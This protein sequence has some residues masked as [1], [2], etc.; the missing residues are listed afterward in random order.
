[1]F[2]FFLPVYIL[3][4]TVKQLKYCSKY[5][6]SYRPKYIIYL[7]FS[8]AENLSEVRK[9][10]GAIKIGRG[11]KYGEKPYRRVNIIESN[12]TFCVNLTK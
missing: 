3:K 7:L 6:T 1:M 4:C 12:L 11:Q 5:L 9:S 2:I 8:N 10:F